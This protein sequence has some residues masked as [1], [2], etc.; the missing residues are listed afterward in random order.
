MSFSRFAVGFTRKR[1]VHALSDAAFRLWTSS[2]D[3]A[4]EELTD[5][6]I[7]SFALRRIPSK[8]GAFGWTKRVV[9]EL[10]DAG[11]W[12][13]KSNTCWQIVD[14]LG[15]QDS[16]SKVRRKREQARDRMREV[17]ANRKQNEK[18]TSGERSNEVR[19]GDHLSSSLLSSKGGVGGDG[20]LPT[21]AKHLLAGGCKA[22]D[23]RF[24]HGDAKQWPEVLEVLEAFGGKMDVRT[25]NDARVRVTLERFA[26]GYTQA[27]LIELIQL[28]ARHEFWKGK[29]LPQLF[30]DP[31]RLDELRG[32]A[33][34]SKPGTVVLSEDELGGYG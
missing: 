16:A 32:K 1:R 5:G 12:E 29:P 31:G 11:L 20:D 6:E 17:R 9:Q 3:Y 4:R 10:I 26:D 21:R 13:Q 18:R 30:K 2:I 34:P 33:A 7:D 19:N 15:W 14:F 8:G 22:Q 27:E 23:V 25:D 28:A 24:S